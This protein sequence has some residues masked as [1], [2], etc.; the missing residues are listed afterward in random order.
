MITVTAFLPRAKAHVSISPSEA[1]SGSWTMY[2]LR[3]P[4]ERENASTV[5]LELW[6]PVNDT[7][8]ALFDLRVIMQTDWNWTTEKDLANKTTKITWEG[9][10]IPPHEFAFFGWLGPNPRTPGL[11]TFTAN[12]TY[13]SSEIV[14]WTPQVLITDLTSE[15]QTIIDLESQ[16]DDLNQTVSEI[17][18]TPGPQGEQGQQGPQGE[19]GP[20]GDPTPAELIYGS[21]GLS[22][23]ALV[24]AV[25]SVFRKAK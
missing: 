14:Q 16:I 17:E 8:F 25:Y 4:G 20:Q 12:Q 11:Y 5:K 18:L 1:K 15:E 10:E 9:S 24:V 7:G 22:V 6:I 19:Q 2:Q 21:L 23:L 13:S 3:V